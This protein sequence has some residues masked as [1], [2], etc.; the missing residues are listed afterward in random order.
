MGPL[1]S[2]D[3]QKTVLGYIE[4]GASR[5]GARLAHGRDRAHRRAS[6][7]AA[8]FVAPTVFDRVGPDMQI[9]QEEIFGPRGGGRLEATRLR[10]GGHASPTTRASVS[11]RPW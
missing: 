1:V 6:T 5:E 10:R 8:Y 4:A 11:A 3:A 9:A 2:A 7:T